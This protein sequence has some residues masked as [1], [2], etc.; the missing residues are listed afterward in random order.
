MNY[1]RNLSTRKLSTTVLIALTS[2]AWG[3]SASGQNASGQSLVPAPEASPEVSI[4]EP[5]PVRFFQPLLSPFKIQKRPVA[6]A[7]MNNT[8]RLESLIRAGNLYLSLP[9][10]IA[11]SLENNLDIAVQRYGP[12]LAREIIRRAQSGQALRD[13]HIPI[14]AGPVSISTAGVSSLAIGTGGGSGV[15]SGGGLV[16]SI[17]TQPPN[18]DP[19]ITAVAQ[20]H[21]NTTPLSNQ[22]VS[23]VDASGAQRPVLSAGYNQSWATGT[24]RVG[25]F[26]TQRFQYNSPANSLNPYTTGYLDFQIY[27]QLLQGWGTP[28]IPATSRLR[29]TI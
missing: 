25:N 4:G 27:Q 14:A 28:P 19:T 9:D 16:A 1:F 5:K 6:P 22:L 17:G 12:Y 29:K 23:L 11:L 3:Q 18:L 21:H 15:T 7:K 2:V 26:V 13:V 10:V 8:S 24:T 20:F